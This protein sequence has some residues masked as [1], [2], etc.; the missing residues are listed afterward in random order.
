MKI[1]VLGAG[2]WGL[3]MGK[4]LHENGHKVSFWM[5]RQTQVDLLTK[6]SQDDSKLSG[7]IMPSGIHYTNDLEKALLEVELIVVAVP[8]KGLREISKQCA[9]ILPGKVIVV[10]VVKGIEKDSLKR[11]S[12]IIEEEFDDKLAA[13]AVLSGPSHAE[14]V[15]RKIPTS[16]VI[17]SARSQIVCQLQNV[18]MTP[19][20]RVYTSDDL[21]GVEV[22]GALKN[23]IAISTGII[24]GL[25]YGDNTKGAIITRGLAE[26]ARIGEVLGGHVRTFAGLAGMGDLITT[27]MSKHSRNR[28]VGECIG[29]GK[30]L[31][32]VLDSMSMVAEGVHSTLSGYRVAQEFQVDM[33]IT[34]A[35]YKI[36]YENKDPKEAAIELMNRDPK[37]EG[38]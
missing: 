10:S 15:A 20:F 34:E 19:E 12:Q 16:V 6:T 26:I 11:M 31:D 14:E 28:F 18:F 3:A 2:G 32:E 22:C 7:I 1:C 33:P 36:L 21:V 25:G 29:S 9:A 24:D 35:V 17:A 13:V 23:V 37:A 30:S 4:L 8:S 27:C 38:F 5:R